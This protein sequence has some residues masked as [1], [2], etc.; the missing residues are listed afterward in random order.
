M[1]RLFITTFYLLF[2][3]LSFQP[4]S[5]AEDFS[6]IK[7]FYDPRYE[8]DYNKSFFKKGGER[9][10]F[11]RN[12]HLK[13]GIIVKNKSSMRMGEVISVVF[14]VAPFDRYRDFF[15]FVEHRD[16]ER[17]KRN[18]DYYIRAYNSYGN[19][20]PGGYDVSTS[21][22]RAGLVVLEVNDPTFDNTGTLGYSKDKLAVA[23]KI[24]ILHELGHA[25]AG[26]ADEYSIDL[27]SQSRKKREAVQKSAGIP[28]D[29]HKYKVWHTDQ[30]NIEYR[31][32]KFLKWQP[33]IDKGIIPD[34][35]IKRVQIED[36]QDR[37]RFLIPTKKCIMNRIIGEDMEFCPV[38][39][40]QIIDSICA[41]TGVI[42]PWMED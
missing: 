23:Q 22:V 4:V 8:F 9:V 11:N 29:Y 13:I 1:L 14:S 34:E 3:I 40:L 42:P 38:C 16:V 18:R 25:L 36:G 20:I 17:A 19:V 39:Q 27:D 33:L 15:V 37:G 24:T 21:S 10:R 5:L 7:P 41:H 26:L 35:K 28:V 12:L 6:D 2:S 32:R 30:P 31:H